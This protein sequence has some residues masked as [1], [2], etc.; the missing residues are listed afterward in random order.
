MEYSGE[1]R[2]Q[3]QATRDREAQLLQELEQIRGT[4]RQLLEKLN[5]T[6]PQAEPIAAFTI[7]QR[8]QDVIREQA[9]QQETPLFRDGV[10]ESAI[11]APIN[12]TRLLYPAG[13]RYWSDL[14][15]SM[16]KR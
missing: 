2:Q 12:Q 11:P 3:I 10:A 1:I 13:H 16:D 4:R 6:T 14:A 9:M 7:W 8:R 5:S 15:E